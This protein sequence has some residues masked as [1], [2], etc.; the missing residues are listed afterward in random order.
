M[1]LDEIKSLDVHELFEQVT[2]DLITMEKLSE[3]D[4]PSRRRGR[5]SKS[6]S[7]RVDEAAEPRLSSQTE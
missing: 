3:D 1:S 5:F 4:A 7:A 6:Q 2:P